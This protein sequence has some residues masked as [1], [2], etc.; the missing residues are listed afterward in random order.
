MTTKP[1]DLKDGSAEIII[2][3][4]DGSKGII[5]YWKESSFSF[6]IT[7]KDGESELTVSNYPGDIINSVK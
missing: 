1:N 3:K 7:K 4:L 2:G 6:L 5:T